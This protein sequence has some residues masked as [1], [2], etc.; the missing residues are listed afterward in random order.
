MPG[1]VCV[2][3]DVFGCVFKAWPLSVLCG[4]GLRPLLSVPRCTGWSDGGT[5]ALLFV[6]MANVGVCF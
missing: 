1:V 3:A 2:I 5:G 6:L 4:A